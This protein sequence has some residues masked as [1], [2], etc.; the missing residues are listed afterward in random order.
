MIAMVLLTKPV[1]RCPKDRVQHWGLPEVVSQLTAN[2]GSAQQCPVV[3]EVVVCPF[4]RAPRLLP[5]MPGIQPRHQVT[6]PNS[7]PAGACLSPLVRGPSQQKHTE[8]AL[9]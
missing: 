8:S 5:A 2:V 9:R 4:A 6:L 1:W 7:K 3:Q